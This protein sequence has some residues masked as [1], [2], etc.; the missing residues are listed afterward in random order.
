RV[1]DTMLGAILG[2]VFAVIFSSFD[3]RRHLARLQREQR[4]GVG[5]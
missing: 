5:K 4:T 2:I 1:F 3:D